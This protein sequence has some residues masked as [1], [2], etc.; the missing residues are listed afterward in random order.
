MTVVL[1]APV[2][3]TDADRTRQAAQRWIDV[4][5]RRGHEV[6]LVGPSDLA[7][8]VTHHVAARPDTA[9]T[10]R[11]VADAMEGVP[12]PV[13]LLDAATPGSVVTLEEVEATPGTVVMAVPQGETDPDGGRPDAPMRVIADVVVAAGS[14]VHGI[15]DWT[16]EGVGLL[17]VDAADADAVASAMRVM[18][19]VASAE[20]WQGPAWPLTAVAAVRAG[21]IVQTISTGA[22]PW[23]TLDVDDELAVEDEARLRIDAA[24][25]PAQ[26]VVDRFLGIPVAKWLSMMAWKVGVGAHAVTAVSVVSAL[27][28]GLLIATG[29]RMG[30]AV[31]ALFLLVSVILDRVDGLLARA[32]RTVTPFGTW[33]DVTTDRLRE[34]AVVIG[35]GVGVA[36][37]ASPRWAMASAVL[38]TLT[39]AHLAAAS[40]RT[41]RG[42][43]GA[44]TP[45]RLPL[46]RL[47]EPPMPLVPPPSG[48]PAP[49]W[50][51][52]SIS[53]GDGA[54]V[55]IVGLMLLP[56]DVLLLVLAVLA[57]LSALVCL[58]MVGLAHALPAAQRQLFALAD[59]GPLAS[60]VGRQDPQL[61]LL[62]RLV[63][64][65]LAA[66]V[67]PATWAIE[68]SALLVITA[69]ADPDAL[70]VTLAWVGVLSFH[71]IDVATRLRVLGTPPPHW[72]DILG[73]GALGR[74]VF[75]ALCA[76]AGALTQGLAIG[77]VVLGVIYATEKLGTVRRSV[78]DQPG[79]LQ[80]FSLPWR[81]PSLDGGFLTTTLLTPGQSLPTTT[82]SVEPR[83]AR[84]TRVALP[85]EADRV[86]AASTLLA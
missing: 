7:V 63:A 6:Y 86:R 38:A 75:V 52:F 30:A 29:T 56:P 20:R 53:R 4:L 74:V 31:G 17:R 47:D 60:V 28:S 57:G 37:F 48:R 83:P 72:L 85:S 40:S 1:L 69:W 59:P 80:M 68:V 16:H 71:R 46:D 54:W 12:P 61:S 25:G 81:T 10:V 2:D 15:A 34:A 58:L 64:T 67:P 32:R 24:V 49:A 65:P 50:L 84:S 23:Q 5:E 41:A 70:P 45:V 18:G 21:I 55:A 27:M 62:R 36:E 79:M 8:R 66:W 35:L 42:W 78:G 39:L 73:L 76:A 77:A 44:P 11:A 82:S 14:S 22:L 19:D 3:A 33:L 13:L 43:G 51:P 26:G 9:D